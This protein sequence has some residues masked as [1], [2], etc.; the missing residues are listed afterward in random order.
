MRMRS[1]APST[2]D[3]RFARGPWN[4]EVGYLGSFI[5]LGIGVVTL[6]VLGWSYAA[7]FLVLALAFGVIAGAGGYWA[8]SSIRTVGGVSATPRG[9]HST[10][11]SPPLAA[12]R[13]SSS[14][15]QCVARKVIRVRMPAVS[16]DVRR[17]MSKIWQPP[18]SLSCSSVT[19]GAGVA[20]GAANDGA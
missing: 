14:I 8:V 12:T 6:D 10:R 11:S 2:S 7:T 3:V 9:R 5:G 16:G 13:S 17:A 4:L 18:G 15:A 20:V 1:F 19:V